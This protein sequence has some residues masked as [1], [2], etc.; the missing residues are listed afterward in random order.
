MKA[1]GNILLTVTCSDELQVDL[2]I[3]ELEKKISYQISPTRVDCNSTPKQYS[4]RL[5]DKVVQNTFLLIEGNITNSAPKCKV[6]SRQ[7][8]L[9]YSQP[10]TQSIPDNSL[11]TI[12]IAL[13]FVVI[14]LAKKK[15][16]D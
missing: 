14:I 4:I 13:T 12:I 8:I 16:K 15:N 1:D 10:E 9:L 2:N 11:I 7:T 5:I 3:T 6:C